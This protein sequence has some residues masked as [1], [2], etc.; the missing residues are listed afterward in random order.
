MVQ[1]PIHKCLEGHITFINQS[2][3]F[4]NVFNLKPKLDTVIELKTV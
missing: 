3:F 1:G 2:Y 4:L